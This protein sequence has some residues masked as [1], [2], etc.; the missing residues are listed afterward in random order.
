MQCGSRGARIVEGRC[1]PSQWNEDST[2]AG[3]L[4]THVIRCVTARKP[5]GKQIKRI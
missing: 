5:S 2:N 1:A 4:I 3:R